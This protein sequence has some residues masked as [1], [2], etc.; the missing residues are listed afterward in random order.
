MQETKF[1]L[2][3]PD[4]K[5]IYGVKSGKADGPAIIVVHGLTGH[6]YEYQF[7]HAATLWDDEFCTYRF[8][9]YDGAEDARNLVDCTLQTH[10]DDLRT[11]VAEVAK[12]HQK[13][14]VVGHSYGGPSTMIANCTAITAASLW[15]PS[16]NLTGVFDLYEKNFTAYPEGYV[17]NWGTTYLIGRAMQEFTYALDASACQKLAEAVNF[18]VQVILAG[19]GYYIKQGANYDTHCPHPN[20]RDVIEGTSHC[21]YENDTATEVATLT[22]QWFKQWL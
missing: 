2:S 7:K 14:F 1:T 12:S 10:A 11:V 18:P 20:R 21:F 13:I 15:D 6:M 3:T 22:A 17:V 16:Y 19:N 9:L 8:N 5:T 4:S